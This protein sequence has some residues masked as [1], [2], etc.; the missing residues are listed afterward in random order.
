MATKR[1]PLTWADYTPVLTSAT[2]TLGTYTINH[3]RWVRV[4][5]TVT[6]TFDIAITSAGTTPGGDILMTLPANGRDGPYCGAVHGREHGAGDLIGGPVDGDAGRA[7][8]SLDAGAF[9][10]GE[11][12]QAYRRHDV[13]GG[14]MAGVQTVNVPAASALTEILGHEDMGGGEKRTAR[15]SLAALRAQLGGLPSMWA[16]ASATAD[17]DPG[18]GLFRLEPRHAGQRHR[19]LYRQ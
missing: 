6:V 12:Q 10:G 16:F 3:A 13:R 18:S 19:S 1:L 17:A 9:A 11:R 8:I 2:G 7:R 5:W 4:G 15:L 14:I